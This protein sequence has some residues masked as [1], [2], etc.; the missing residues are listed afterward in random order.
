MTKKSSEILCRDNCTCNIENPDAYPSELINDLKYD[1][2]E[3]AINI[4]GCEAF[5]EMMN[6]LNWKGEENHTEILTSLEVSF[7]CAGICEK[8]PY[9]LFSDV[10][11]GPPESKFSCY[12]ELSIFVED[13]G[14]FLFATCWSIACILFLIAIA[15]LC[16]CFHPNREDLQPYP[17]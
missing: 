6:R 2:N 15:T 10:N 9:Y 13:V 16:L 3:G 7:K 17:Y 1:V 8:N 12:E 14:V 11:N 4:M 5:P